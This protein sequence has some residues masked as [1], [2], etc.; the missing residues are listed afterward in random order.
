MVAG[1]V[2]EWSAEDR[3]A[4]A[5]RCAA[6]AERRGFGHDARRLRRTPCLILLAAAAAAVLLPAIAAAQARAIP[7]FNGKDLSGW[8]HLLV[9]PP[10]PASD[11]WSVRGGVLVCTGEP[12]GYLVTT[13]DCTSF[14]LVVDVTVAGDRLLLPCPRIQEQSV[15]RP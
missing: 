10:V 9:D 2:R 7:L 12:L 15:T 14:K 8:G 3:P 1:L 5:G 4:P 11:V 6:P 13:T